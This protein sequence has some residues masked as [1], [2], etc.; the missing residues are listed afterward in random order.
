MAVVARAAAGAEWKILEPA[1]APPAY[2]VAAQEFQKLYSGVTGRQLEIT[3]A[4]DPSADLVVI[5]SDSVNR[6]ARTAVE[7]GII[8]PLDVGADTDGYRIKSAEKDGRRWLFSRGRQRARSMRSTTSSSVRPVAA[9]SG[10][11]TSFRG[12][13]RLRWAGSTCMRPAFRLPR[14]PLLRPSQSRPLSGRALGAGAVGREI[15][16]ILKKRLNFFMLRIG[17]DDVWQKAFPDIV[18]YPPT[19]APLPEAVERS[20]D[21][22][23]SA[24]PLRYRGEL[25]KH[26][27]AYARERDLL[28]PEDLG[29]M[30]HW[31]SRTP[32]AFLEKAQPSFVPQAGGAY[33]G[34]P[35][36]AIWDIRDD[37]NLDNYWKLT[38]AH[39][40]HYGAPDMFHTIGLAER[41]VFTNHADNLEMKLYAYRRIISKLREHYPVAPL[42]IA[43]WISIIRL[44]RRRGGQTGIVVA[45]EHDHLDYTCDLPQRF[46]V[47]TSPSGGWSASFRG[48]SVSSMR[49]SGKL[50]CVAIMT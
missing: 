17:M 41:I 18:P 45:R 46:R 48:C 42:L 33:R 4:P 27:L 34:N 28:H 43:S 16:W 25:R 2:A 6:F 29:T 44:D 19:N 11:A 31:Y 22:R 47:P 14:A 15:D 10:T 3:A 12:A 13:R 24:W 37:Q 23:T 5:G 20:Y 32:K 26:V 30:T 7:N 50:N 40:D 21:D 38:Q 36:G 1:A 49:M 35:T 9:T 39:V 8:P